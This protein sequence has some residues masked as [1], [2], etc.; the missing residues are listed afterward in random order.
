MKEHAIGRRKLLLTASSAAV[1]G[2][3]DFSWGASDWEQPQSATPTRQPERQASE[4]RRV[5]AEGV[6][7]AAVEDAEPEEAVLDVP[8]GAVHVEPPGVLDHV[9]VIS[10]E[11]RGGDPSDYLTEDIDWY[12]PE[13]NE[14]LW[15]VPVMFKPDTAE[16]IAVPRARRWTMRVHHDGSVP[17]S[18]PKAPLCTSVADRPTYYVVRTEHGGR[19][20]AVAYPEPH[21]LESIELWFL[22]FATR[23]FKVELAFL[24]DDLERR[25][26]WTFRP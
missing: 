20:H 3:M 5:S 11:S 4:L 9:G 19:E 6:T 26:T 25:A 14:V 7:P 13:E 10:E 21:L 24:N 16:K 23:R 15:F 1:A 17:D 8:G 22:V 2:C 12:R 18:E